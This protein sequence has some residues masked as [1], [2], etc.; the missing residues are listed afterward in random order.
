MTYR[1]GRHAARRM[2]EK[3]IS[4]ADLDAVISNPDRV[5]AEGGS[6]NLYEGQ[7]GGRR[8][9]VVVEFAA[10]PPVVVTVYPL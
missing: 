4:L 9:I 10:D 1:I 6:R 7:V 8:L 5:E 2:A 3:N